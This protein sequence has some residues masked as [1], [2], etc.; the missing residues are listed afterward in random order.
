M[1]LCAYRCS[2]ADYRSSMNVVDAR[3]QW[4]K[5]TVQTTWAGKCA[6]WV[7]Q[8]Q[9]LKD[10]VTDLYNIGLSIWSMRAF[11]LPVKYLP[12]P[13]RNH[14]EVCA[15]SI[16]MGQ[17]GLWSLC[18]VSPTSKRSVPF[19]WCVACPVPS[20]SSWKSIHS[21][22]FMSSGFMVEIRVLDEDPISSLTKWFML[23]EGVDSISWNPHERTPL[24]CTPSP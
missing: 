9:T 13:D 6:V 7:V 2:E 20:L 14:C 5:G 24:W 22:V 21:V 23:N 12:N 18:G 11:H 1:T 10:P 3:L 15:R 17:F 19:L 4:G 8:A 16:T